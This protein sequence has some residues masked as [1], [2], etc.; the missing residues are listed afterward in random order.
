MRSPRVPATLLLLCGAIAILVAG[1][2]TRPSIP[3]TRNWPAPCD[4][5]IA[6]VP[7]FSKVS[8]LL[9]RGAQPTEEGFR[10]LETAGAKTIISLRE[11]HDDLPLLERT[12]LKYLRIPM[13]AW[14]PE[15]A[16]L[17]LFLTQLERIL[18]D[19]DSAPVFVH[20]AEGKDRTGY[21]IAAYRMLFE[22]WTADDAI[23]EMFDFRFNTIW[24]RNPGFL[25]NLDIERVRK[26]MQRAP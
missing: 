5:C 6:G 3:P 26:R 15:E 19:P 2:A 14:D 16:E 4:S 25:K 23:H 18:K 22:N 12:K 13:D 17:V 21:S 24:F 8:V 20:C 7:N 1:C 10:N 9:W 11:H